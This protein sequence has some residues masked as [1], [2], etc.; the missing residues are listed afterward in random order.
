MLYLF[1]E[2]T[3]NDTAAV[4]KG[5][6]IDDYVGNDGDLLIDREA[7]EGDESYTRRIKLYDHLFSC[8]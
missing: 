4:G 6:F 2:L 3:M 7:D 1:E 5:I 8:G